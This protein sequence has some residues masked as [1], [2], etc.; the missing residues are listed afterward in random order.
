M[1]ILICAFVM[2]LIAI[3]LGLDSESEANQPT[4]LV[5]L[6]IPVDVVPEPCRR[7]VALYHRNRNR[8]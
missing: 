8:S 4:E 2:T 3:V 7:E 1:I 6:S 5:P